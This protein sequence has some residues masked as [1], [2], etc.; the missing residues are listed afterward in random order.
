MPHPQAHQES[1]NLECELLASLEQLWRT[2]DEGIWEVRGPRAHFT[3]SKGMA[4]LAFDRAVRNVNE[5]G[6]SGPAQHWATI[7]D[8]IHAQ[9]CDEG[10]DPDLNAF[11]QSY[12]SKQLDA[13]VL[14]LPLVGFLPASDPAWS[15]PSKPSNAR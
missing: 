13:A 4:W 10:F 9:I 7:R 8:E 11:T 5:F 12:G 3:H 2:P 15:E 14:L 6:L 1:W